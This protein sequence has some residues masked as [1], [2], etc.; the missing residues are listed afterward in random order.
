MLYY[1]ARIVE[2]E[3]YR[4]AAAFTTIQKHADMMKLTKKT[5]TQWWNGD[6][7]TSISFHFRALLTNSPYKGLF[8]IVNGSIEPLRELL[9]ESVNYG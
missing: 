1:T 3:R 7:T 2:R 8:R 5:K 4:S 6:R 9:P